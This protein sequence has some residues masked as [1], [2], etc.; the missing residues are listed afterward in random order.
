MFTFY[1][2]RFIAIPHPPLINFKLF[3]QTHS[4]QKIIRTRS[5]PGWRVYVKAITLRNFLHSFILIINNYNDDTST[6]A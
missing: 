2:P 1:F 5:I 3:F 6:S 4:P